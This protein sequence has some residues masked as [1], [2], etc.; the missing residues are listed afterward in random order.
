MFCCVFLSLVLSGQGAPAGGESQDGDAV[1]KSR[2]VT[3][4]DERAMKAFVPDK[5]RIRAMVEEGMVR[6]TKQPTAVGAWRSLVATND[7]VGIKVYT[8]A[9]AASG[10]RMRVLIGTC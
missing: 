10:T 7:V 2:I 8:R 6:L 1:K 4:R 3:V 5:L 9:G